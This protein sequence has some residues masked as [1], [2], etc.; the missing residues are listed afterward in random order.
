MAGIY[1][2]I[3]FCRKACHYCDFHFSTTLNLVDEVV[4]AIIMEAERMKSYIDLPIN[5]IY[6]G[7]GTPSL[8]SN[9]QLQKIIEALYQHYQIKDRIEFTIEANPDDL[10]EEKILFYANAG[11]NRMSI[12]TQSFSNNILT[13]LNRSHSAAQTNKA[14]ELCHQYG[15]TNLSLDLIYGIPGQSANDWQQELA[16]MIALNPT[17]IS[18]YALTIEPNTVFGNW[19]KKG[20]LVEVKD[21]VVESNYLNMVAFFKQNGYEHY[22]VS[23]FAKPGFISKHN[24]AYWQQNPYLGLGPGAHSFNGLSRHFN[25]SSNP[26]YIKKIKGYE[27]AFLIEKLTRNELLTEYI[28]TRLRTFWGLDFSEMSKLFNFKLTEHQLSFIHNLVAKNL[29]SFADNRL[30]LNSR[31]FFISDAIVIKLIPQT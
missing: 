21:E 5:T 19:S 12:G 2:H 24:A 26:K 16:K 6:F 3:P 28:L 31:G 29:A 27:K 18:C 15:I 8:L 11:I 9:V 14:V 20:K 30:V 23:N 1:I 13:Y 25:V 4:D 22:E 10:T 7:G 17:H